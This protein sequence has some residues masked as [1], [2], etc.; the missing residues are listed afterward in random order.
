MDK[1]NLSITVPFCSY[2]SNCLPGTMGSCLP[3]FSPMPFLFCDTESNCRYA[4]RNDYSYWLST[5]T[6]MHPTM[7]AITGDQL[8]SYISRW[9]RNNFTDI[10]TPISHCIFIIQIPS[11]FL[12]YNKVIMSIHFTLLAIY[13]LC[14][15]VCLFTF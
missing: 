2:T 7:I 8:A 1:R 5:D 13:I 9:A 14:I 4:S 10:H 11:D 3:R 15:C 6:P 12:Q